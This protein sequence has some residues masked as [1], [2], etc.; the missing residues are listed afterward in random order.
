MS[1][2]TG[3]GFPR[4]AGDREAPAPLARWLLEHGLL[5]G[6][7]PF[8]DYWASVLGM[9]H[10]IPD[11]LVDA[12]LVDPGLYRLGLDRPDLQMPRLRNYL[13]LFL[14]GPLL[15]V[16]RRFRRLGRYRARV[17]SEAGREVLDR[18]EGLR[19]QLV[20]EGPRVDVRK[21]DRL[22]AEDL[23][24]PFRV[25]GFASFFFATYKL[26]LASFT[27]LLL[28]A[29][30]VPVLHAFDVYRPALDLW[31]P[32]GFPFL[33]LLLYLIYRDVV[34][35]TLGALSVVIVR[36]LLPFVRHGTAE[37]WP[38]FLGGLAGLF[39]LY[40][41]IDWLFMPRPVPPVLLLY[42][43]EG[44]ARSYEREED[45]PWWLEGTTYWVWR[46]LALTPG[47]LSKFWERDWER[48][49]LWIRA[50][51]PQAG[52][53]EWV[54]TDGHWRELWIP[55]EELIG[56]DGG[57]RAAA[58]RRAAGGGPPGFWLLEVDAD[59]LFHAPSF[60]AATFVAGGEGA[61]T[62]SL[63]HLIGLF[64]RRPPR[65]DPSLPYRRLQS[66]RLVVGGDLF[67]DAPEVAAPL[68]ARNLLSMPWRY[69]R[70]PLGAAT[71]EEDRLYGRR[72][73]DRPPPAADPELQIKAPRGEDR[74]GGGASDAAFMERG[75]S[76]HG[77]P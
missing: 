29:V 10:V 73:P 31:V 11:R 16:L 12:G 35:A 20:G 77:L 22:L 43:R 48:A 51:G 46:Y 49:E 61:P 33:A 25:S 24:D 59:L 19:V 39:V 7:F 68:I 1:H 15:I 13:V 60:R 53:L 34:T 76:E 42:T 70:Y 27:A 56:P 50:D 41:V 54:V 72:P 21:G 65:D 2:A 14:L 52:R 3:D 26:P 28:A 4:E 32:A 9:E 36:F 18:L 71:R 69:W 5:R 55:A 67:E 30:T 6:P 37:G 75:N 23:V 62:R 63:R 45:A 74:P 40:L 38:A 58:A 64:W 8:A 17:A 44:P 47:E 57:E 66:A